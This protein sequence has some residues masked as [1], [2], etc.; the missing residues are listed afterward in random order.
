MTVITQKDY[1]GDYSSNHQ[2]AKFSKK[3]VVKFRMENTT[4]TS[5]NEITE[6][7]SDYIKDLLVNERIDGKY[8]H[9]VER[10]LQNIKY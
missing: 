7:Q 6:K 8:K 1:E 3:E 2:E 4:E 10:A 5:K 9:Y